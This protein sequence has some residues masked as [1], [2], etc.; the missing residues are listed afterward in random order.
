MNYRVAA[1]LSTGHVNMN[2]LVEGQKDFIYWLWITS[3]T[4]GY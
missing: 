4:S 2:T 1:Y 3:K